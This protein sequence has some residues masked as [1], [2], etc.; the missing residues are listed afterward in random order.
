MGR[1]F[2][3][4]VILRSEA[5]KDPRRF[6]TLAIESGILRCAQDDAQLPVVHPNSALAFSHRIFLFA[7][8]DI[9][10]A[11]KSST[12]RRIEAMPGLG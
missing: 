9:G 4:H 7:S 1:L 2:L 8:S 3:K 5:T 10:R 6:A 11:R 12:F